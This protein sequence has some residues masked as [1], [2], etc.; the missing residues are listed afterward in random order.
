[1]TDMQ[2]TRTSESACVCVRYRFIHHHQF[3]MR[4]E[5]R[6]K[7]NWPFCCSK[8]IEIMNSSGMENFFLING[9]KKWDSKKQYN[10]K[11]GHECIVFFVVAFV[12][13]NV[14]VFFLLLSALFNV[15]FFFTTY[16]HT[17]WIQFINDFEMHSC[18]NL[19]DNNVS[20]SQKQ[21]F[22]LTT[23]TTTTKT[24]TT[25]TKL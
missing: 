8:L 16:T 25:T 19:N 24:T 18:K 3:Q 17:L 4:A 21:L 22:N 23:T 10:R 1:M 20:L 12:P 7:H 13:Y 9:Q 15:I 2:G 5:H 6:K 14:V 11:N